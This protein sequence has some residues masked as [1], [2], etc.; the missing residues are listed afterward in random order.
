MSNISHKF[1]NDSKYNSEAD[2][3]KEKVMSYQNLSSEFVLALRQ[4]FHIS[5]QSLMESIINDDVYE[6]LNIIKLMPDDFYARHENFDKMAKVLSHNNIDS[7]IIREVLKKTLSDKVTTPQLIRNLRDKLPHLD[8][9]VHKSILKVIPLY[10]KNRDLK[11]L[12]IS[13][14]KYLLELEIK[15]IKN[16]YKFDEKTKAKEGVDN[17]MKAYKNDDD[18]IRIRKA[19]NLFIPDTDESTDPQKLLEYI[20]E[21]EQKLRN[22]GGH[23]PSK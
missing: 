3:C 23:S 18:Y 13:S 2:T 5:H 14:A 8:K 15:N 17:D 6:A 20:L 19:V 1:Y 10:S 7:N 21:T 12:F 11:P 4:K 22:E 16:T 9:P